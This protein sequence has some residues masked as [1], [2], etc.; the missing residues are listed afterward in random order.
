MGGT[1]CNLITAISIIGVTLTAIL[2]NCRDSTSKFEPG[3]CS[4]RSTLASQNFGASSFSTI[5]LSHIKDQHLEGENKEAVLY[6]FK[7]T[8]K[9]ILARQNPL[10]VPPPP[11]RA[12]NSSL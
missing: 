4:P 7:S 11:C 5:C 9:F 2:I 10:S 12:H 3:A 6:F 1:L 8:I